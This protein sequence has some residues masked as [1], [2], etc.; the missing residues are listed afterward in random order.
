MGGDTSQNADKTSEN[1]EKN[2]KEKKDPEIRVAS[3]EEMKMQNALI[4]TQISDAIKNNPD[5]PPKS[6]NP[7]SAR[8]EAVALEKSLNAFA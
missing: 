7:E 1:K 2:E 5:W 6:E 4:K 8:A 3:I